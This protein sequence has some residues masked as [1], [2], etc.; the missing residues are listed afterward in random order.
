MELRFCE[1]RNIRLPSAFPARR[2]VLGGEVVDLPPDVTART[3]GRYV[4]RVTT[5]SE[6][7]S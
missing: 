6:S 1:A 3:S 5:D 2:V 4:D 7:P